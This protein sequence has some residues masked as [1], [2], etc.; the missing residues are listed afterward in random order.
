MTYLLVQHKVVDFDKWYS[1]FKSHA[2]AQRKAGLK[3]LQLLRD[4]EDPNIIVCFFKIDDME[5]AKAFTESRHSHEA[6]KESGV[7]GEPE[8]LLLDE[9]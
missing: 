3:D 4:A 2:E 5:K 1:V 6:Q 8:I 9:I 7:I